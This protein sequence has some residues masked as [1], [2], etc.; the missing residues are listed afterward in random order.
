MRS[1]RQQQPECFGDSDEKTH[2]TALATVRAASIVLLEAGCVEDEAQ[3]D[4]RVAE[5]HEKTPRRA[6]NF[7]PSR[8]GLAPEVWVASDC[9]AGL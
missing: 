2:S 5:P 4:G 3:E 6:A 1:R 8:M 7:D 9:V